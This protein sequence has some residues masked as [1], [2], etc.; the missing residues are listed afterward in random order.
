MC[1]GEKMNELYVIK[2]G[3]RLRC[4]YTT[5]SCS[6]AAAKA[7]VIMLLGKRKIEYVDIDTPYGIKLKL[8]VEKAEIND[9]FSSC[10]IVKDS[11]DDPDATDG[12]EIFA[13]VTRR[14]DNIINIDGGQGIGRI[15]RKG[16]FGKVGE[17]AIN[18]V[19]KKMIEDEIRRISNE[20]YNVTIYA[21]EGEVIAKKTFNE[22]IGIFGGISIIG[23]TGIVEPMSEAALVKTIYMEI[24]KIYDEGSRSIILFPGN[25]GEI[26]V[27]ELGLSAPRVKVSNYIGDALLYCKSKG[28]A[29]ITLVGHIGKF[30]KLSLGI[31]NTHSKVCDTRIE[32]FIYYLA[33][34]G[35]PIEFLQEMRKCITA[36]EAVKIIH[37]T[38][39][40]KVFSYMTAGCEK[41]IRKYL[42]TDEIK[43]KV[44]IYSMEYGVL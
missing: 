8:K 21:P 14:E 39:W 5:G 29:E 25:Y 7:S 1:G 30:S 4:G 28:F 12:I 26:M 34:L 17:A 11:G 10:C 41:R 31:F 6:T 3:K 33:M 9:E 18:P 35:A 19:P 37:N 38:S 23:T 20:G 40:N 22:N 42:K 44:Y 27:K 24:D 32:A 15:K 36:E 2:E 43:I 16:L 13:K